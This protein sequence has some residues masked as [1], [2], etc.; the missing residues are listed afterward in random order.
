MFD[1]AIYT[2]LADY[3]AARERSV[4]DVQEK[5]F[6]LKTEK[7]DGELY[8]RKLREENFLNDDRYTKAFVEVHNRKKWGKLKIRNALLGKGIKATVI[9]EYLDDIDGEDYGEQIKVLAEKKWKSLRS[10]ENADKR[11]KVMRFL[12]GRGFEMDKIR[13]AVKNLDV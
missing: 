9:S 13:A 6:K 3:C 4:R 12:L 7:E 11:N 1:K 10:G 2:K 8:I 5:L